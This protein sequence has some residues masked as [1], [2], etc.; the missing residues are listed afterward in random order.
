MKTKSARPKSPRPKSPHGMSALLPT[1]P[2]QTP[3][4]FEPAPPIHIETR[5]VPPSPRRLPAA[6]LWTT[7]AAAVAFYAW[8]LPPLRLLPLDAPGTLHTVL[9]PYFQRLLSNFRSLEDFAPVWVS[10]GLITL[11]LPFALTLLCFVPLRD[12]LRRILCSRALFWVNVAAGLLY[13]RFPLLLGG[14]SNVDEVEF[15]VSATKLL[16]DPV[17]FRSTNVGTSGPLNI[18]PLTLPALFGFSPDYASS[19]VVATVI[20]FLTLFFLHRGLSEMSSD[21][22]ARVAILPALGFFT[23]ATYCDFITYSAELVPMLLTALAVL[24]GGRAI[25]QPGNST[26]PLLALGFLVSAAFFSKMQSVPI[27]AAAAVCAAGAVCLSRQTRPWWRPVLLLAAGFAPLPLLNFLIAAAAGVVRQATAGYIGGNAHFSR[28][29]SNFFADVPAFPATIAATT[30]MQFL[31]LILLSLAAVTVYA[32]VRGDREPELRRF[33]GSGIVAAA[34]FAGLARFQIL[35]HSPT[36]RALCTLIALAALGILVWLVF[37]RAFGIFSLSLLGAGLFAIYLSPQKYPHYMELLIV[38]ISTLI[39]WLLMRQGP[40]LSTVAVALALIVA[41]EIA[42]IGHVRANLWEAHETMAFPGGSLIQRLTHPGAVI[43]VWGWRPEIYLSAGRI[44]ATRESNVYYLGSGA[45]RILR[46]LKRTRPELIVD[47]VD[48]SC[49]LIDDR[50]RFGFEGTPLVNSYIYDN[51]ALV[52]EKY[53]ERFYL[54]KDL[55]FPAE[56]RP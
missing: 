19:R 17:F 13:W 46:D 48:V 18:F 7:V 27:L 44:P 10:R 26:R 40:R 52:A 25:R 1:D 16:T 2:N 51:Y 33:A 29:T 35:F 41:A 49:C 30:E 11:F 21:V 50:K 53:R 34:V 37:R 22:L 45:D 43:V 55:P 5:P 32:A 8:R 39:G 38:P 42:L 23:L 12:P 14:A 15:T 47:A 3:S 6:L 9:W 24:A 54:R 36:L 4:G 28:S 20:I 31:V 56:P